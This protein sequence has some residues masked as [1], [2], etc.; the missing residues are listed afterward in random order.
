MF[1]IFGFNKKP[2]AKVSRKIFKNG[3]E[4]NAIITV[5]RK[6]FELFFIPLLPYGKSYSIYIPHTDEYYENGVFMKMPDDYL[7]ICKEVGRTY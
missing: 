6:Y 2:I 4:M 1:F 7:E 5:Y 3:F